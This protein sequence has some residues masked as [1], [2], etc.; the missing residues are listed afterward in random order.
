MANVL[1]GPGEKW[2]PLVGINEASMT[3]SQAY[4]INK[5]SPNMA[6]AKDFLQYWTSQKQNQSFNLQADWVPCIVGSRLPPHMAAYAPQIEGY[7]NGS[8]WLFAW[9]EADRLSAVFEGKVQAV[10]SGRGTKQEVIAAMKGILDDPHYG[11]D[12]VLAKKMND[13]RNGERNGERGIAA[14]ALAQ[15]VAPAAAAPVPN[16][17]ILVSAQAGL[18]NGR[19]PE[20]AIRRLE[21]A[22]P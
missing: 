9:G 5:T 7:A 6:I 2:G 13:Y 21:E 22:F 1:P 15:L 17:V 10:L 4:G 20:T 3:A 19:A 12:A 18:L 14:Q 16:Y 8:A 11:I